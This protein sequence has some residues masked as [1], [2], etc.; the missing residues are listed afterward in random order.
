MVLDLIFFVLALIVIFLGLLEDPI[1]LAIIV[2]W[3]V[4]F[5]ATLVVFSLH[6]SQGADEWYQYSISIIT[7]I[8]VAMVFGILLSYDVYGIALLIP[9]AV[10][11]IFAIN[12][13]FVDNSED[14]I[15]KDLKKLQKE[16]S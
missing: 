15:D 12:W 1:G 2:A 3:V 11:G 9:F 6:L 4:V 10:I 5:M 16:I 13:M 7:G 8:L 14:A